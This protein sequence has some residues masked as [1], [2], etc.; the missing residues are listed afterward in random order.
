MITKKR[1]AKQIAKAMVL[2]A[3]AGRMEELITD[4]L[5]DD[6]SEILTPKQ[7]EDVER[8]LRSYL[9][10]LYNAVK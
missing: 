9:N 6:Y 2:G 4:D 5:R 1:T 8:H 10:R 7:M 3:I